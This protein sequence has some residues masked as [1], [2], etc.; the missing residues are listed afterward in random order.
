M[1]DRESGPRSGFL[2]TAPRQALNRAGEAY[3]VVCVILAA[4]AIFPEKPSMWAFP[5]LL[6][7]TLPVSTFAWFITYAGG[8][9][10]FGL[11]E[12]LIA[13]STTFVVWVALATGQMV[14]IRALFRIACRNRAVRSG[15]AGLQL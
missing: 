4:L 13:K 3:V 1:Q 5:A 15:T 2:A 14:A 11:D 8:L 7:A 6:V 10:L 9:L 12:G